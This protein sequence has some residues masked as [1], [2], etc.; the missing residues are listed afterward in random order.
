VPLID[1]EDREHSLIRNLSLHISQESMILQ[2]RRPQRKISLN[3][4]FI[5]IRMYFD[6]NMKKFEIQNSVDRV[7]TRRL[8]QVALQ[9]NIQAIDFDAMRLAVNDLPRQRRLM[10]IFCCD[11]V[12]GKKKPLNKGYEIFPC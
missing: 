1:P 6:S 2:T 4:H 10:R 7:A 5:L 12:N 11:C 8:A 3:L 9:C